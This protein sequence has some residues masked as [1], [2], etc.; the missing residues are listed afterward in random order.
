MSTDSYRK[1]DVIPE[2]TL[3]T[4]LLHEAAVIITMSGTLLLADMI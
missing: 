1:L 2:G 4:K 3:S